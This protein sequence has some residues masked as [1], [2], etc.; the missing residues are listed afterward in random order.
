MSLGEPLSHDAREGDLR[1]ERGDD[2][3]K[4]EDG[5]KLYAK[6]GNGGGGGGQAGG[7]KS[8]KKRCTILGCGTI[9][10]PR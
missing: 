5:K 4:S 8:G 2:Y 6:E 9:S 10:H 7:E 1:G 3:G